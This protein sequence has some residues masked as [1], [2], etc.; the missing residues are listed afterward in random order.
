MPTEFPL[1]APRGIVPASLLVGQERGSDIQQPS[2]ARSLKQS[3]KETESWPSH[4]GIDKR[5]DFFT[6]YYEPYLNRPPAAGH[7]WLIGNK[8]HS[9]CLYNRPLP[10]WFNAPAWSYLFPRDKMG[11]NWR[12]MTGQCI[13][14][15]F[16]KSHL[17][18]LGHTG[19][20]H[21]ENLSL[22][23]GSCCS[24]VNWVLHVR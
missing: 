14:S 3:N 11:G 17:L 22:T 20:N 21:Q 5:S 10:S 24:A 7:F 18:P 2:R 1:K 19:M 12:S 6:C 13:S 4:W 23:A 9:D 16:S 8:T 15:Q